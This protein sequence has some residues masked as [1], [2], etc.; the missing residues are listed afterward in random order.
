MSEV[1]HE[2]GSELPS[3]QG[4]EGN[5]IWDPLSSASMQ[6]RPGVEERERNREPGSG[7]YGA[8]PNT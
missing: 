1:G 6:Q 5:R 3:R 8:I 4:K 2:L 7:S